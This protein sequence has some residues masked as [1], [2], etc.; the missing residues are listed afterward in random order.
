MSN[1]HATILN[2]VVNKVKNDLEQRD[3]KNILAKLTITEQSIL[4]QALGD[5]DLSPLRN[6]MILNYPG[7]HCCSK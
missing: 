3:W 2:N 4:F 5:A 7:I 1:T 6:L